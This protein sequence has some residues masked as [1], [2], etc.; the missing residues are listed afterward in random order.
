MADEAESSFFRDSLDDLLPEGFFEDDQPLT[1]HNNL[2]HNVDQQAAPLT[3]DFQ[4]QL[5]Q[6]EIEGFNIDWENMV[7]ES[8]EARIQ[9][10][11][12]VKSNPP[13]SLK[14]ERKDTDAR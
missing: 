6:E 10:A 14:D 8:V 1:Y 5:T 12:F 13:E 4:E 11:R 7:W 2:K 9:E 3:E